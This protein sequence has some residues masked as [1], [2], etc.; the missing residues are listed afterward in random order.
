MIPPLAPSH[1]DLDPSIL[2]IM[3]CGEGPVPLAS[4]RAIA[5]FLKKE[6]HP[7]EMDFQE[8]FLG[9]PAKVRAEAAQLIAADTA[10]IQP[11]HEHFH[12]PGDRRPGISLE[13]G[14]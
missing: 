8:D 1:F 4:A 10:D 6:L 14:R 7:W 3:H 12:R 5:G 11:H 2:W 9:L 13:S